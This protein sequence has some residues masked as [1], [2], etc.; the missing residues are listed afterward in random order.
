MSNS[1]VTVAPPLATNSNGLNSTHLGHLVPLSHAHHPYHHA[2]NAAHHQSAHLSLA[3][4]THHS[5]H[6]LDTNGHQLS[7]NLSHHHHHP[8]HHQLAGNH[9]QPFGLSLGLSSN[10]SPLTTNYHH[11]FSSNLNSDLDFK[12]VINGLEFKS[13]LNQPGGLISSHFSTAGSDIDD[14]NENEEQPTHGDLEAFAKMFKQRRIK[15]GYTQ[16]DVG[17]ALG[18]LYGNVFSQTTI[19]R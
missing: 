19:C 3:Q 12:P 9:N 7:S 4:Q 1:S 16:A 11:H 17:L 14:L 15:L 8:A 10:L 2:I 6:S 18:S 13:N 5:A